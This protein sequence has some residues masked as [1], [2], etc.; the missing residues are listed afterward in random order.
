MDFARRIGDVTTPADGYSLLQP[1]SCLTARQN[2]FVFFFKPEVLLLPRLEHRREVVDEALKAFERHGV[3]IG[4]CAVLSGTL[5]ER[6]GAMRRHYGTIN[7][8]SRSAS[9]EVAAAEATAIR[10]ALGAPAGTPL[11]G[12]HEYLER[13]SLHA[14]R[15]QWRPQK[16]T[17]I[18]SGFYAQTVDSDTGPV[19]VVNGFHPAHLAHFTKAGHAI[20]LFLLSSDTAWSVLRRHMLG[21]TFPER[22]HVGSLRRFFRDGGPRFGIGPVDTTM[23][24]AHMSA[25]PFEAL[26]EM[27]NFFR[28]T[29]GFDFDARDT[30]LGRRMAAAGLDAQLE[31]A[32]G[33]PRLSRADGQHLF[34]ASEG[35]DAAEAVQ[36]FHASRP[37]S[38]SRTKGP[39]RC[40]ASETAEMRRAAPFHK[41]P[42]G[43]PAPATG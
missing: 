23:N 13:N 28:D 15:R 17:R 4:G 31:L 11:L 37:S 36:L 39:R 42:C 14:L 30:S 9:T 35:L 8:L 27:R 2:Q 7:R 32:L 19:I 38:R 18:R 16:S 41:D 6:S 33:N 26:F 29:L 12:G 43:G 21:D 20:V 10:L 22:A 24:C 5:L 40:A 34:N 25:G 3:E 1:F